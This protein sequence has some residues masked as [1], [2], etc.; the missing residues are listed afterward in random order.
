MPSIES[1]LH[2]RTD[3][4]TFVVHFTRETADGG[5][6]DNLKAILEDRAIEARNVFGMATALAKRYKAIA[7]SQR[8]VCF[9]ETPLEHAWMMCEQIPGRTMRFDGYGLAFTRTFARRRGANPV[10]YLDITPGHEWLTTPVNNM[11]N[12]VREIAKDPSEGG[13]DAAAAADV[14]R[15]TPFIEQMGNPVGTRKEFWWEREWRHVG[16]FHF[17]PRDLVV[18]FAPE[19]DHDELEDHLAELIQRGRRP[20]LVDA[21]WGLERMIA[22]LTDVDEPGPFPS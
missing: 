3:L 11:V 16:D 8:T 10:W 14:L 13:V 17:H 6:I 12:Q 21:R 22:A 1:L 20:H 5:A 18:V 15:L 9:T 7:D 19:E 4:S 2:R